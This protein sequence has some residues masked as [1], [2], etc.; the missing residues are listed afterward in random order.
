[1][2]RISLIF[3]S[4]ISLLRELFGGL[5]RRLAADNEQRQVALAH[6]GFGKA[7]HQQVHQAC[8]AVCADDD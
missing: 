2:L 7:A 6:H 5:F 1:M 4:N 8:A 3:R